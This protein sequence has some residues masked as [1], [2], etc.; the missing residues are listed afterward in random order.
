MKTAEFPQKVKRGSVVVRIYRTPS[1]GCESYTL[2]FY[3]DGVRKRPTFTTL[4]Q[5]REEAE[6]IAGRLAS[7]DSYTIKMSS[8][9]CASYSRARQLLD[10][11][12]IAIETAAA[13]VADARKRLGDTPLSHVIDDFLRRKAA[14]VAPKAISEVTSEFIE[15]KR[16][17]RASERYLQCL[18]YCMGK[19]SK[20]FQGN[21]GSVTA[22]EIDTWLRNSGLSPRSR[23]NLRNS[24]QT[25]FGF[26]KA[27]GYLPKD[28]SEIETVPVVKD[29]D[30]EIEVFTPAELVEILSHGG[31]KLIPFLV[32]GA[33]AGIR[34]AEIQ[35]LHWTDLRFEDGIIEIQAG[36]AKTASRRTIPILD[37]LR[38]WLLPYRKESGLVCG[39]RNVAFE[40]DERVR[41]INRARREAWASANKIPASAM[42]ATNEEAKTQIARAKADKTF[43]R[44][45]IPP[46]AETAKIEGWVPFRWKHNALRHSFI[47][48]RV[49]EIQ[50]VNQVA[51]EAGNSPQ[52]I[53]RHYRELVR[54]ADAKAWFSIGLT[55]EERAKLTASQMKVA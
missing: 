30:G 54:A 39:Y 21:I 9:D 7:T 25:L 32:L 33:F 47:S 46:G 34:H 4:K 38:E 3:Q 2:S 40:L 24:V 19:F 29:R 12:G 26:A 11:L 16:K 41:R 52:M 28:H 10:P 6:R 22:A 15:A 18:R 50:N 23:N 31:E 14:S 17:D 51:L 44:G 20:A 1:H 55:E 48:Y 13:E 36:K 43:R 42:E 27:R 35:R 8:A 5:A 37:N 53:F 45:D 49:A